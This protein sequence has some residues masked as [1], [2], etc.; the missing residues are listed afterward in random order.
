MKDQLMSAVTLAHPKEGYCT[1]V[2]TDAYETHWLSI[3]TQMPAEDDCFLLQEQRHEPLAF[4]SGEFKDASFNWS[5]AEK[6]AVPIVQTFERLD[7]VLTGK[8]TELH[9]DHR[10]LIYIFD[11]HGSNPS[12]CR[13]VASKLMRWSYK[14]CAFRYV[15]NHV[16]GDQNLWLTCSHVG[17]FA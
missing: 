8:T 5:T 4:L 3:T 2:F 15:I 13:H 10:N 16:P 1:H 12:V 9:T 14:M 6:K 7:Y 11:S 17:Q